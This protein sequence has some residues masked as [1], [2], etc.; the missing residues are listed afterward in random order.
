MTSVHNKY[1]LVLQRVLMIPH[2]ELFTPEDTSRLEEVFLHGYKMLQGSSHAKIC[3][4]L[5][6]EVC[7]VSH[8]YLPAFIL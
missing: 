5:I 1:L 7:E 4:A 8:K 6:I 2:S 3:F